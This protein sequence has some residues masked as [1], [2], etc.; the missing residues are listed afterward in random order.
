MI[1]SDRAFDL[2]TESRIRCLITVKE[3]LKYILRST[4][5]ILKTNQRK[6]RLYELVYSADDVE[7]S[8]A[9]SNL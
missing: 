7:T 6:E 4:S 5:C 8:Y 9:L 2:A 3:P 1:Q